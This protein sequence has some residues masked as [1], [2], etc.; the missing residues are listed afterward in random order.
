MKS[1]DFEQLGITLFRKVETDDCFNDVLNSMS[2]D[3]LQLYNSLHPLLKH[4]EENIMTIKKTIW[5]LIF[6]QVVSVQ[7]QFTGDVSWVVGNPSVPANSP[8][9]SIFE[10]RNM[11]LD[12]IIQDEK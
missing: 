1:Y 6:E 2:P 12:Q 11:I 4:F 3:R 7:S 5:S 10:I 9:S 8:A